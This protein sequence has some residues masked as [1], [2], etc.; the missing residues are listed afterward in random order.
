MLIEPLPNTGKSIDF[1]SF[2]RTLKKAILNS[3]HVPVEMIESVD[4]HYGFA[5]E[6]IVV[7]LKWKKHCEACNHMVPCDRL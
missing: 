6:D 3:L 5:I 7:P 2:R 4:H 1:D